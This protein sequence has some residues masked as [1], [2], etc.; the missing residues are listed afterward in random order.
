RKPGD[1]SSEGNRADVTGPGV[2]RLFQKGTSEFVTDPG[3]PKPKAPEPGKDEM[4][5]T[6]VSFKT[7]MYANSKTN[8]VMFW[9]GVRVLDMPATDPLMAVDLETIP[10]DPPPGAMY[11]SGAQVTVVDHGPK[12]KPQRE[13]KATGRVVVKAQE[14]LG[15]AAVVTF[16]EAKDQIIF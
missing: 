10:D 14:F 3:D 16:N 2:V 13:M 5:L 11:L 1:R 4:K 7:R 15:R 9:G 8:T 6:Y 12:G